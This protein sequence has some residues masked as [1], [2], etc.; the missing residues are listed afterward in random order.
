MSESELEW[1]C[2]T[3]RALFIHG[4]LLGSPGMIGVVASAAES[5]AAPVSTSAPQR[6]GSITDAIL[7]QIRKKVVDRAGDEV[8]VL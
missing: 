1:F 3:L 7:K 8:L 5:D 6:S 2:Q 4:R